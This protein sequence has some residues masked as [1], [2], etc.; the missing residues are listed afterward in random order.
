MPS[1]GPAD[2]VIKTAHR[3]MWA[4]GDYPTVAEELIPEMGRELVGA[5]AVSTGQRVLDVAAGSGNAAIPAAVA[6]AEVTAADLTPEMFVR[7]RETAAANRVSVD[8]VRADAEDLPFAD[9]DFDVAMSCVGVM[10]APHHRRAADE[11]A[12]VLRPGGV[13]G[14]ASWTPEGF[15]GQLLAALKPFAPAPP[16]GAEP[17][18]LWGREDHVRELLGDRVTSLRARRAMVRIERFATPAEFREYFKTCYGPTVAVARSL[19]G[20]ADRMRAYDAALDGVA[21]AAMDA[22]GAMDWEYLLVTARR[23]G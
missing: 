20:D 17:A 23:S 12:R 10:F 13:L 9:A 6:G 4:L 5:C 21:G 19:E 16:P 15:V 22:S 7:G 1:A 8:W 14:L 2:A 18:P 11:M 3:A